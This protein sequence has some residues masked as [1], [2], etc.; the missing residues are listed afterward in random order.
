MIKESINKYWRLGAEIL[1][2][3]ALLFLILKPNYKEK[4]TNDTT[5]TETSKT[6]SK[7]DWTSHETTRIE[8][9]KDGT[10]T[11]IIDK[12]SSGSKE[13]AKNDNSKEVSHTVIVKAQSYYTL[14]VFYVIPSIFSGQINYDLDN[15]KIMFGTRVFSTPLFITTGTNAKL[16]EVSIGFRWEF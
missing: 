9:K 8:E 4:Y 10:K 13:V 1:V 14:D 12:V 3:G 15:M 7:T 6:D 11:T 2:V 16:N 5:K